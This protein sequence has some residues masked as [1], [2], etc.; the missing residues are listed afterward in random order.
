MTYSLASKCAKRILAQGELA[1]AGERER[2]TGLAPLFDSPPLKQPLPLF[3][4]FNFLPPVYF[5]S[6]QGSSLQEVQGRVCPAPAWGG[7][8]VPRRRP[9][10]LHGLGP[11]DPS[12][13]G[14]GEV[15]H[16]MDACWLASAER[17]GAAEACI[18]RHSSERLKTF[19]GEDG[20][21][22]CE[23][24]DGCRRRFGLEG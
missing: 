21:T 10:R 6:A 19:P 1:E 22:A 23:T 5:L 12:P 7:C 8:K 13:V 16:G 18:Q 3:I 9:H 15:C 4:Q 2:E 20:R 24:T 17:G 11:I 14:T